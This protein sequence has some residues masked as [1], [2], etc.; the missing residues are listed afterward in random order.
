VS[1]R[2]FPA[3]GSESPEIRCFVIDFAPEPT[4]LKSELET[5]GGFSIRRS[6]AVY[7]ESDERWIRRSPLNRQVEIGKGAAGCLLAH[8][9]VWSEWG[10]ESG[11]ESDVALVL[12]S[13]AAITKYGKTWIRHVLGEMSRHEIRLL[14][15]GANRTENLSAVLR[16]DRSVTNGITRIQDFAETRFLTMHR[17]RLSNSFGWGTH[18]YLL[19]RDCAQW[20]SQQDWGF[21]LPVDL[22][23]RSL[24][25]TPQNRIARVRQQLWSTSRE[26]S[27]IDALGR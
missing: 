23:L 2:H 11:L 3:E 4:R 16:G 27:V 18:A 15:V 25:L 5:L 21:L 24:S 26:A 22:W 1:L 7:A 13:D 19:R 6:P 12:E 20:L 9:D 14:Q 17:P 8:I 10:S